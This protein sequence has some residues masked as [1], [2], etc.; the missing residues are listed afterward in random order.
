MICVTQIAIGIEDKKVRLTQD[1][2]ALKKLPTE[3]AATGIDC[4]K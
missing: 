3:A 2:T 4:P 1:P